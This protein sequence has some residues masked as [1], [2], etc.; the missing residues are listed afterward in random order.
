MRKCKSC[1]YHSWSFYAQGWTPWTTTSFMLKAVC[2][3]L[4]AMWKQTSYFKGELGGVL[5]KVIIEGY[6]NFQKTWFEMLEGGFSGLLHKKNEHRC[7]RNYGKISIQISH[8]YPKNLY[9][10]V[11]NAF[12]RCNFVLMLIFEEP[13]CR[14]IFFSLFIFISG[15]GFHQISFL[16]F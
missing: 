10:N 4:L 9:R 2:V 13:Y 8:V 14:T 6:K 1:V 16:A 11:L 5:G 3:L 15:D 12:A 7:F